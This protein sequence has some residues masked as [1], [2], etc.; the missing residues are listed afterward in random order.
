MTD[1]LLFTLSLATLLYHA[2][3]VHGINKERADWMKALMSKN[4]QEFSQAKASEVVVD[5]PE[6]EEFVEELDASDSLFDKAMK[7]AGIKK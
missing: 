3:Y 7:V 5:R 2:W 6:K 1:I 4:I